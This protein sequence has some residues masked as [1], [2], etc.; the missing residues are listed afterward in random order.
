MFSR[1]PVF[2]LSLVVSLVLAECLA[3]IVVWTRYSI[4]PY[5]GLGTG[6]AIQ[7]RRD[8][9]ADLDESVRRLTCYR[10]RPYWGFGFE[11][12]VAVSECFDPAFLDRIDPDR[13]A[14]WRHARTD[15]W[16]FFNQVGLSLPRDASKNECVVALTGGS[17]ATWLGLLAS[18]SIQQEVGKL[19]FCRGKIVRFL[20]FASFGFKQPQQLMVLLFMNSIGTSIDL[21][22]NVDGFNE[23]A[24]S[25]IN[26]SNGIAVSMPS[27]Q[28]MLPLEQLLRALPEDISDLARQLSLAESDQALRTISE[29][30]RR[31]H[32]AL[33][34]LYDKLRESTIRANIVALSASLKS[35]SAHTSWL[36]PPSATDSENMTTI[37]DLWQRSSILLY[38][39]QRE[40]GATY[41]HV[42]Q[43]NQYFGARVLS[44]SERAVAYAADS[45]YRAAVE[46]GYPILLGR[47][48]MFP[49]GLKFLNASSALDGIGEPVYVDSCCHVNRL[50]AIAMIKRIFESAIESH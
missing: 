33:T 36:S 4:V 27:A 24:L 34:H 5:S 9:E 29:R 1:W 11:S 15:E 31:P 45:P 18:D 49:L 48:A 30:A 17:F 10:P 13:S 6:A 28:H 3:F 41:M 44:P 2:F 39:L 43:P 14:L 46:A 23:V 19:N 35:Q 12:G 40:Q 20:N 47:A 25:S 21:L 22:I 50:A 37:A 8:T 16:G 32:F 42:L 7:S 38:H 26:R